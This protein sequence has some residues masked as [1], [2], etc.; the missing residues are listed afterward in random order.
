MMKLQFRNPVPSFR[1]RLALIFSISFFYI[2]AP[3]NA[4]QRYAYFRN[5]MGSEFNLVFYAPNDSIA[6]AASDSVFKRIDYLNTILSDY[7]DG[8]ETNRLSATAGSGKAF[9]ASE[10][11][12][13][14]LQK[15]LYYSKQSNGTFDVTVGPMVQLWRRAL[16]RNFFPDSLQ[17]LEVKQAVGY[18]KVRLRAKNRAVILTQKGMRIDFGGIG[19]GYAADDAL[20]VLRAFNIT[21]AFLDAG[22]D[23]TIGDAP[24]QKEGW[25][26]EVSS[27]GKDS[28]SKRVLILSHCG[29]ATSGNTYR[30]LEH[31]GVRYSHI[32]D[33]RTGLGL[34]T[35]TRTTVIAP[36]GTAADALATAF[37]VSGIEEGKRLAKKIKKSR[38][39][40]LEQ[41]GREWKSPNFH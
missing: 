28:T 7:L 4:Q 31:K 24:P 26:I 39:W 40:L 20:R 32:V 5:A 30:F 27:G 3:V 33:P 8:S 14:I 36:N 25:E 18:K 38:V 34:V 22:G 11:L 16:R 1:C 41:N 21:C 6:K 23:L 2:P 10:I 29:V 35:H 19:K 17:I 15:S 9:A 12:F 37:S 13:D